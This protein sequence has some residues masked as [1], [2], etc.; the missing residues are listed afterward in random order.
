MSNTREVTSQYD[1]HPAENT[2]TSKM[3]SLKINTQTIKNE[4][5]S[6]ANIKSNIITLMY[7]HE[8]VC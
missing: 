5:P 1:I 4:F 8:L 3:K 2:G 6:C 7:K